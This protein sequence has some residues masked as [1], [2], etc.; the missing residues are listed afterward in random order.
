MNKSFSVEKHHSVF[1]DFDFNWCHCCSTWKFRYF[2]CDEAA[3]HILFYIQAQAVS[4]NSYQ[5]VSE[6]SPPSVLN[7]LNLTC[8]IARPSVRRSSSAPWRFLPAWMTSS[9]VIVNSPS[10]KVSNLQMKTNKRS[11]P[12]TIDGWA[13]FINSTSSSHLHQ[14]V[15]EAEWNVC[16]VLLCFS[17]LSA[18]KKHSFWV[19]TGRLL[20]YFDCL[21]HRQEGAHQLR[22]LLKAL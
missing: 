18:W 15:M 9:V 13:V 14:N 10:W 1:D 17:S 5:K 2:I 16:T 11:S 8:A 7:A 21:F 20:E 12:R 22:L 6:M 19:K 3:E 4:G